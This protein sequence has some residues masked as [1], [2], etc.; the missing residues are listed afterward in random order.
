M[1][2]L[3]QRNKKCAEC[4]LELYK[5]VEFFKNTREV[6]EKLEPQ[7]NA[8]CSTRVFLKNSKCL[9]VD[10]STMHEEQVFFS[11]LL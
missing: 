10:N 11:F 8:S 2:K 4:I 9:H 1:Y 6:L 7:A 5:H 3:Y